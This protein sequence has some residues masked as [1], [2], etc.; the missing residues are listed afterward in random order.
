MRRFSR[1]ILVSL[2]GSFGLVAVT[3]S[4]AVATA[5][6]ISA[7]SAGGSHTCAL[8][9][10]GGVLCWGDNSSGQIGYGAGGNPLT[11]AWVSGLDSGVAAV[12]AGDQHTCALTNGGGVLCWGSNEFGQVG[13]GA[14]PGGALAPVAV[15]GLDSGVAAVSAGGVHTCALTTGGEVFC[16]GENQYGQLGDGTTV[17][18]STPAA[19]SGLGGQVVA[20]SAGELDTCALINS[21]AVRC[22]GDNENGQLG[23]GTSTSS[24]TPVDVTGLESGVVA[25][26]AGAWHTCALTSDGTVHCW[27]KN[28]SGELGDGTTTSSS[29]PVD[30]VGLNGTAT[31][32]GVG[33]AHTCAI[34][35]G[36]GVQCWGDNYRS[37]L[38][39]G[40]TN[41]SSAPVGVIGLGSGVT[42]LSAGGAGAHNCVLP[43]SGGVLCW[44]E[45]YF[46]QLGDGGTTDKSTPVE[47]QFGQSATGLQGSGSPSALGDPVTF[48]ASVVPTDGTGT[49]GFAADGAT[50]SGC[51]NQPVVYHN[52]GYTA[53]CTTSSLSLG[54][55]S[56]TASYSG[57]SR[58]GPSTSSPVQQNVLRCINCV[59]SPTPLPF[60]LSNL[61]QTLNQLLVGLG[62]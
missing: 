62:I 39:D 48:T 2:V 55:H 14:P 34:T 23:N 37:Q 24:S 54:Q 57:D 43:S 45:G 21:G 22:W 16:W 8:T 1:L 61:I 42:A 56:I 46:G 25:V 27:G 35:S 13:P 12:S 30:V 41:N 9:N 31:A 47:V 58:Y 7:L 20:I 51:G 36:G 40:T 38:G 10:A 44:G 15:T 5:P 28:F 33:E 18:R 11:P 29:T 53:T 4:A 52:Y 17:S 60:P 50:I 19:V 6:T 59:S 49:V 32:V 26:S 3:S